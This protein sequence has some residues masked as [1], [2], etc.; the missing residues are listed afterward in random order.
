LLVALYVDVQSVRR[1]KEAGSCESNFYARSRLS[2]FEALAYAGMPQT[3]PKQGQSSGRAQQS[4][5]G[6]G[7]L[8]VVGGLEEERIL[9]G[10]DLV[11]SS[12]SVSFLAVLLA[13]VGH[14]L[15][16]VVSEE[17]PVQQA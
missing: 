1:G 6:R 14:A 11:L 17:H 12:V 9:V 15:A 10:E 13:S 3:L 8:Q 5:L 2:A 4:L 16:L 7:R